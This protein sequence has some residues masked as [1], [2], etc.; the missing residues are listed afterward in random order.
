MARPRR[1]GE[2]RAAILE[3]LAAMPASLSARS[4]A[5]NLAQRVVA[6]I[7]AADRREE[8][9]EIA[10]ASAVALLQADPAVALAERM[11]AELGRERVARFEARGCKQL[12][13][14]QWDAETVQIAAVLEDRFAHRFRR[15]A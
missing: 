4:K 12:P 1:D 3:A 15:L 8:P 13:Q 7:I 14:S 11:A 5:S 9:M 10:L 6:E 2:E